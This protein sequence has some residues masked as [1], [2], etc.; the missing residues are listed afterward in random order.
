MDSKDALRDAAQRDAQLVWMRY[1]YMM[2]ANSILLAFIG[3][4]AT[5]DNVKGLLG[6][7]A[8]L[9]GLFISLLWLFLT[10]YGWSCSNELFQ[11]SEGDVLKA[12]RGW[13]KNVWSCKVPGPSWCFSHAVIVLFCIGWVSLGIY[14]VYLEYLACNR[15]DIVSIISICLSLF[16]VGI[17]AIVFLIS[18]VLWVWLIRTRLSNW[19]K[20]QECIK[21]VG[22]KINKG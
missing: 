15:C 11:A 18:L 21:E 8:C 9:F 3:Q 7:S 14:F 13:K 16:F 4:L 1:H 19:I 20:H 5:K 10:S 17:I 6:V 12:Y 2:I 22:T